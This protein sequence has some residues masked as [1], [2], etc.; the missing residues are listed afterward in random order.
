MRELPDEEDG[1]ESDAGPLDDAASGSPAD[2]GR[3]RSGKGSDEGVDDGEALERS[4]DADVKDRGEESQ[5]SGEEICGVGEIEDAEK[6]GGESEDEA[7]G[8]ADAS[9]S[10]RTVG[11]AMHQV[12]GAALEGLV[13]SGRA[14]G[15]YRDSGDGFDETSVEWA[16]SAVQAAKIEAGSGGDDDHGGDAELEEGG[17]VA[18][19]GVWLRG[20]EDLIGCRGGCHVFRIPRMAQIV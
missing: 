4:I 14:A 12:V 5:G 10:H 20:G 11:G 2:E 15:D 9:G 6:N 17:V 7:V 19:Q 18:E 13:E 3:K 16:D 1:E 8:E